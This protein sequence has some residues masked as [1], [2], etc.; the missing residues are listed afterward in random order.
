MTES[1][2]AKFSRFHANGDLLPPSVPA[3]ILASLSLDADS[4]LS[5]RFFSYDSEEIKPY[6]T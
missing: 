1:D 4:G 3:G 2:H 5:G 6:S